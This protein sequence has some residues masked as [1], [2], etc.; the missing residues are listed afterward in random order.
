M[1][2]IMILCAFIPGSDAQGCAVELMG[3]VDNITVNL[4]RENDSREAVTLCELPHPLYCYYQIHAFDIEADGSIGTLPVP[5]VLLYDN[6]TMISQCIMTKVNPEGP[7]RTGVISVVAVLMII[8]IVVIIVMII[9]ILL[10]KHSQ[11][12]GES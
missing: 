4:A 1:N 6:V 12:Q 3:H 7:S 9:I 10:C 5:G 11:K 2:E 8:V